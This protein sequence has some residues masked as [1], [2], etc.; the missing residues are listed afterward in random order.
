MTS[1]KIRHVRL[2]EQ[3]NEIVVEFARLAASV[4]SLVIGL[5][6][7]GNVNDKPVLLQLSAV[8][9]KKSCTA[10]FQLQ[11]ARDS[12]APAHIFSQGPP[13]RLR[14]IFQIPNA[15]FVGKNIA[16]DVSQAA[17]LAGLDQSV[18]NKILATDTA[19][20]YDFAD[21]LARGTIGEWLEGE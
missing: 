5:N 12:A 6:L 20:L 7:E 11:S 10:V 8:T 13:L 3:V 1:S 16:G 9:K 14:E 19:R 17:D 2:H 21:A 4:E 15:E 18:T